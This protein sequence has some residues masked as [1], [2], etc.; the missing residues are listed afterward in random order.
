MKSLDCGYHTIDWYYWR[1]IKFGRTTKQ[2]IDI[3]DCGKSNNRSDAWIH[4]KLAA[5]SP[6][7][8]TLNNAPHDTFHTSHQ[9]QIF[10][11]TLLITKRR[12][13]VF[14]NKWTNAKSLSCSYRRWWSS[15]CSLSNVRRGQLQIQL[16]MLVLWFSYRKDKTVRLMCNYEYNIFHCTRLFEHDQF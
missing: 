2:V 15:A 12:K 4:A 1:R 10:T 8:L 3:C 7:S 14:V 13:Y 11:L 6:Q 16:L 5:N 9:T